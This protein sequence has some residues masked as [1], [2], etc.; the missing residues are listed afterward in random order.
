MMEENRLQGQYAGFASRLLAFGIDILVIVVSVS[1]I[2]WLISTTLSLFGINV[3]QCPA[4]GTDDSLPAWICRISVLTL[5]VIAFSFAPVYTVLLW[6]LGGQ[7]I[8]KGLMGVRVVRLDG[9]PMSLWRG[10][11]RYVGYVF[12][13]LTMGLGFAWLLLDDRRQALHDKV[14]GT[15]V[16][17]SWKARPDE[18]F[19][20][21]LVARFNK[22][23]GKTPTLRAASQ[24]DM[25]NRRYVVAVFPLKDAKVGF[26]IWDRLKSWNHQD[27]ARVLRAAL[28][29]RDGSGRVFVQEPEYSRADGIGQAESGMPAVDRV[30][31]REL[32]EQAMSLLPGGS[33][34]LVAIL[35]EQ[36]QDQ[37]SDINGVGDAMVAPLPTADDA[38]PEMAG[39][40]DHLSP[41]PDAS[42]T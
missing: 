2:S 12:T 22:R 41:G 32:G 27:P 38:G 4:L 14:A 28:V 11:R 40:V 9:K 39:A 18:T 15:C 3:A 7:T 37:L 30:S 36:W 23:R 16:V 19:L 31:M 33:A 13:V 8:G 35:D 25:R 17:Y 5:V 42:A 21:G 24:A 6:S 10:I 34:A 20:K 26:S 29:T 1:V